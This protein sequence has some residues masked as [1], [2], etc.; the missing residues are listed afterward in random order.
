M[1]KCGKRPR[2]RL[3]STILPSW[4]TMGLAELEW[5]TEVEG[6]VS[7]SH[8][9]SFSTGSGLLGKPQVTTHHLCEM[10]P[11]VSSSENI[12]AELLMMREY[13]QSGRA[14]QGLCMG[15]QRVAGP[16]TLG[17]Q[18]LPGIQREELAVPGDSV[19]GGRDWCE[20][21]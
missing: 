21:N 13:V 18:F 1:E 4:E 11:A 20:L 15:A 7:W 5:G 8:R 9:Q 10:G 14:Q 16:A 6:I 2:I 12:P 17:P 19:M 3:S